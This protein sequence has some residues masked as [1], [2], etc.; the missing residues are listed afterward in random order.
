MFLHVA[1]VD[2]GMGGL[3]LALSA[4]ECL[5]WSVLELLV[6]VEIVFALAAVAALVTVKGALASVHAYM[7]D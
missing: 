2:K 5:A 7:L 3:E 6:E 1:T 4:A